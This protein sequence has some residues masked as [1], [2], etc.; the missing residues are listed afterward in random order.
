MLW[1][2]CKYWYVTLLAAGLLAPD[3]S[4]APGNFC[5][6]QGRPVSG[7]A[8]TNDASSLTAT[9][10]ATTDEQLRARFVLVNG[11]PTIDE[12]SVRHKGGAWNVL[13]HRL[14][15]RV[16]HGFRLQAPRSGSSPCTRAERRQ[17]RSDRFGQVQM[18]CFLGRPA[19]CPGRRDGTSWSDTCS[20]RNPWDRPARSAP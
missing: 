8:I 4:A 19:T 7:L 14:T 1:K 16:S 20:E 6:V 13:G 5:E 11:T 9:W 18:G 10:D 12:L 17:G 2:Y 3:L 15:R